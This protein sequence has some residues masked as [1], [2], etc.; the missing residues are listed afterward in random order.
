MPERK[1]MRRPIRQAPIGDLNTRV[2]L[3]NRRQVPPTFDSVDAAFEFTEAGSSG[4]VWAKVETLS[5]RTL[6]DAVARVDRAV[7]HAVTIRRRS[8]VTSESWVLLADG[9]RLDVVEVENFE[10]RGEF[11]R[12]LCE[13]S[14]LSSRPLAGL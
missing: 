5:G 7:T 8:D 11:A 2:T 3:Q 13:A 9:T 10:E 14:G 4:Q 12:L 1:V 6:F